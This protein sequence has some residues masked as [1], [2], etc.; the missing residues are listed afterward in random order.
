METKKWIRSVGI[1][2]LALFIFSSNIF[3]FGDYS[4][5]RRHRRHHHPCTEC[6]PVSAPLDGGLVSI[7]GAAGIAYFIIRKKKK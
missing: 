4:R 2:C 5:Y 6:K 3:A 7:L 1:I